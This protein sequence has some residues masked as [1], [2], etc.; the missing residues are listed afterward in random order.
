MPQKLPKMLDW[1]LESMEVARAFLGF[2]DIGGLVQTSVGGL[3]KKQQQ[4]Y[5]TDK[6]IF[7]MIVA[8]L[9]DM[10]QRPAYI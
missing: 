1:V 8:Y 10:L 7:I 6:Q 2:E 4:R 5:L 3:E 9:A